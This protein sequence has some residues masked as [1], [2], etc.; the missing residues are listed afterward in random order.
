MKLTEIVKAICSFNKE[1]WATY[2]NGKPITPELLDSMLNKC[3]IESMYIEF[4]DGFEMGYYGKSF[5]ERVTLVSEMPELDNPTRK[6][7][8]HE[9]MLIPRLNSIRNETE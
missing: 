4:N 6:A 1:Q 7:G 5:S 2:D 9:L 3:G 8:D